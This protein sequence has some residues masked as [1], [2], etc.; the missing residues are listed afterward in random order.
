MIL[1]PRF[2]VPFPRENYPNSP[3]HSP[4]DYHILSLWLIPKSDSSRPTTGTC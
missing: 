3:L 4:T 1:I 2:H